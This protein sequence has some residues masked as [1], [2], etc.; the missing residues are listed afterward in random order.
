[1]LTAPARGPETDFESALPPSPGERRKLARDTLRMSLLRAT[2]TTG[3][4]LMLHAVA[5]KQA[6]CAL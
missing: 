1:M 6:Q 3:G 5:R 2:G 4:W